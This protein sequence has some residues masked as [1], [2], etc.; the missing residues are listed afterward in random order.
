MMDTLRQ[1]AR[2]ALR[3]LAKS[4][5][6]TLV[7][8]LTLALGIGANTA[9]FSVVNGVLL[10]PLPYHE[11]ERLIVVRETYGD[12]QI[13]TVAG[14]NLV[15][16]RARSSGFERLA[17]SRVRSLTVLG[18]G[19]P[20][21]VTAAFVTSDF[22]PMLGVSPAM[23][24]GFAA[25]EDQG[26]GSV[27][28]ISDGFWRTR[29]AA[30]PR[31]VGRSISLS[32]K[33][34]TIIG[35]APPEMTYPG[36]SQLWVPAELT[37]GRAADRSSHSFDVLG[38]LKPGV[39]LER[40]EADL[41]AIAR[42][43]AREYPETNSGRGTVLIPL[44]TDTLGPVRPALLL[45]SGAVAF[46]LLIACANVANLFLARA[47]ARQR[48]LAVR[49]ALG[50]GRWRLVRQ[51]LVE[52][53]V[54]A[55]AGGILGILLA[56]WGVEL[57]LALRPRG[58]PRLQEIAI[59]GT[60]LAYTLVV[61]LLVGLGFGLFPAIS[62]SAHDP[63]ESFRG[64]GRGSSDGRRRVRF[65]RALVVTQVSLAL[66]L[67]VGAALLVVTVRRLTLIEPGFEPNNAVTF[68]LPIPSAK[69]PDQARH[70]EFI[71]RV[72]AG[73][74]ALPEVRSAGA[75]FFLP[76]DAGDVTGDFTLEGAPPPAQ[77]RE[78]YAGYR[79]VSGDFFQAMGVLLRRGRLLGPDDRV[80]APPVAVVNETFA[81]RYL[82][83]A[84]PVG[85][86]VTF[87]DGGED[88]KYH[89]IV[90]VVADVRHL[91]LTTD[92][93]P[94]IYVPFTQLA[95]D[96]WNVFSALTLSVVVRS[97]APVEALAPALRAAI[98]EV[99]AEQVVA[100]MR[101][102]GELVSAAI[103]R[104]RFSMLL[105]LAFGALSL[106]LAGVGVYGVMAYTVSQRTRELGIRLALGARAASVRGMV[107]RQ[108]LAMAVWGIGLGL[109]GAVALGRLLSGLLYGVSPADPLVLGAVAGLLGAASAVACLVPA[110]RATLVNPMD[111]LR[112]D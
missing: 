68:Q 59:D 49:A 9:I 73:V 42:D 32:G 91:G 74:R 90:G 37:V 103:A 83:G 11:P 22:F 25:G 101:P 110:V 99:D 4:P 89:E 95:P 57:L 53:V 102:A 24:R 2:F 86:R 33:P 77:G 64:E 88:A 85:R 51:V 87:G 93:P 61:S 96:L 30:D 27:A 109:L 20:E 54:L 82:P 108:G 15:D 7:V 50:A 47:G 48:E 29:F 31:V 3:S 75:V 17:A 65:R 94:E 39:T 1:D 8:L 111:V 43:L 62:L 21:E 69:Y 52:A 104:Q 6:F 78:P 13:G 112:R 63:A 66:I 45:L 72:L 10:R 36:Q 79:M 76:L 34:Y 14:P 46:V 56:S 38:R 92:P 19:D 100:S 44:A 84:D 40:A 26:E 107:L 81:R 97:D 67:L 60:A 106:M 23:G 55:V 98:R 35:V 71:G 28:V 41:A 5:G 18:D 70:T 12:G 58:I 16:W 80:G 105:L